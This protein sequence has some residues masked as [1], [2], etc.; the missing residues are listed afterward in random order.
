M[1]LAIGSLVWG[2]HDLPRAITFW[3]PALNYKP[4]RE[5]DIDWAILAPAEGTGP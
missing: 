3:C 4:L 1:P 5:P 2:V